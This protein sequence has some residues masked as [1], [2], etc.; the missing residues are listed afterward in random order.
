M[1]LVDTLELKERSTRGHYHRVA[2]LSLKLA[3]RLDYPNKR[4]ESLEYAAWLHDVGKVGIPDH[5]LLKHE[6]LTAEEEKMI[7]RHPQIGANL[8]ASVDQIASIA[9]IIRH[10]HERYDG[11][12]YPEGLKGDRIPEEARIIAIANTYD[13]LLSVRRGRPPLDPESALDEIRSRA[14]SFFDPD[15]VDVFEQ[16]VLTKVRPES[17]DQ[18]LD[19]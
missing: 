18:C 19:T 12:G 10:H 11:K 2:E 15:L 14:G 16:V 8:V 13:G 9:P 7:R 6:V 17:E 1:A 3:R 4:C 5:I